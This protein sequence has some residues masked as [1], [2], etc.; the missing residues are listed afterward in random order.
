MTDRDWERLGAASGT[1]FVL[2]LVVI[3]VF[4]PAPPDFDA[5]TQEIAGYYI[6]DRDAIQISNLIASVAFLF[7]IWF[8]GCVRSVLRVAE[9]GTGRLSAIAFG[10]GLV[11]TAVFLF[12][13]AMAAAA[14]FRPEETNPDL[15][16][17]L[18]DINFGIA[19]ALGGLAFAVFFAATALVSFRTGALIAPLGWLA[20]VAALALALGACTIFDDNGAFS[21]DGFFGI[22]PIVVVLAWVLATSVALTARPAARPVG[23][24]PDA[25]R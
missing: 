7:L 22:L 16:R 1:I 5:P 4:F 19:P 6:D 14:A 15:I 10:G 24:V 25:R 3:F 13:L 2:L 20:V 8:L 17:L 21:A 23:E 9:G 12:A 18:H 11:G